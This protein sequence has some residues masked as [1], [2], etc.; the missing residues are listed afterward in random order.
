VENDHKAITALQIA[1]WRTGTVW[2]CAM[3]GRTRLDNETIG[4]L[5]AEWLR[6]GRAQIEIAGTERSTG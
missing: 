2:E 4:N 3:K 1:G 6:S 5:L